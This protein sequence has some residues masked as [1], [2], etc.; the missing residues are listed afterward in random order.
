MSIAFVPVYV[1]YLGIEAYGLIGIF[2]M[3]QTCIALLDAGITPTLSRELALSE[4]GIRSPQ[5]TRDLAF[6]AEVI[7]LFIILVVIVGLY[8]A[9]PALV[10][11]WI[12]YDKLPPLTVIRALQIMAAVLGVRWLT[13]LYR[14][15][16]IG[17]QRQIWLNSC[18]SIFATLRGLGAVGSWFGSRR[19]FPLFSYTKVSWR[20]SRLPSWESTSEGSCRRRTL[21]LDSAWKGCLTFGASPR[22]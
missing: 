4:A 9:A 16:Y 3:L 18:A 20:R 11:H 12:Q 8:I 2:T 5:A 13:S 6:T 22:E 10:A 1:R 21:R 14:G 7:Y 15:A 19:L 17:L